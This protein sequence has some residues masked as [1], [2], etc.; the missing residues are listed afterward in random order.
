MATFVSDTAPN[1]ASDTAFYSQRSTLQDRCTRAWCNALPRASSCTERWRM[2]GSFTS[3]GITQRKLHRSQQTRMFLKALNKANTLLQRAQAASV[4]A[5]RG[6]QTN[7]RRSVVLRSV[8][9]CW[10]QLGPPLAP[11]P[12]SAQK[13]VSAPVPAGPSYGGGPPGL[14]GA[15]PVMNTSAY[16]SVCKL[17]SEYISLQ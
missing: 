11:K 15:L 12:V 16:N 6:V 9:Y 3:A 7:E 13:Q 2:L 8:H 1:R 17:Q 10:V 4:C 5:V 14:G